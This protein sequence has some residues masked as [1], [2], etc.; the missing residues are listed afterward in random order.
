M[1]NI[2]HEGHKD[3]QGWASTERIALSQIFLCVLSGKNQDLTH[4]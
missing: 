4:D 3:H 2:K 1:K